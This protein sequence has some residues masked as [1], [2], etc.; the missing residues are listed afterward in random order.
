MKL[1]PHQ[2]PPMVE[3]VHDLLTPQ[4]KEKN[5]NFINTV[6]ADCPALPTDMNQ[7][8]RVF[9]NLINN[10]I[11]FTPVAGTIKV[12]GVVD[13]DKVT[14]SI[15]DSGIGINKED[16]PRLFNEFYRIENEINQNVKGTGLGLAL[17]KKII[18]AHKGRIWIESEIEKGA[19]FFFTLPRS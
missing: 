16:I 5:I 19:T 15:N 7:I 3:N 8:E 14:F 6:P 10:A 17:C 4:I 2:I 9:I 12:D 18:E 13:Q 1:T 11:K